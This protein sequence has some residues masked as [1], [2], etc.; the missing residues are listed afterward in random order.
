MGHGETVGGGFVCLFCFFWWVWKSH[1]LRPGVPN[2]W[3][4]SGFL[5][6]ILLFSKQ[7]ARMEDKRVLRTYSTSSTA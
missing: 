4:I 7:A 2:H 3:S 1:I 5:S 6:E